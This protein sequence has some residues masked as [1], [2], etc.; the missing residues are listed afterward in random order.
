VQRSF[1]FFSKE[2]KRLQGTFRSFQKKQG[3]FCS[4]QKNARNVL[5]FSKERKNL[6]FFGKER[7]PN[8]ANHRLGREK[9]FLYFFDL[10]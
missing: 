4:F 9:Y 5:F 3:M 1:A 8:P 6:G 2:S 10:F 7:M